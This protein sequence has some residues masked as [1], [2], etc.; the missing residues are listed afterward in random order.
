ML[1]IWLKEH[2]RY[3]LFE[4]TLTRMTVYSAVPIGA[5]VAA[6]ARLYRIRR[7]RLGEAW[8]GGARHGEVRRSRAGA[9][10]HLVVTISPAVQSAPAAASEADVAAHS[11]PTYCA[12]ISFSCG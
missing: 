9:N 8:L 12:S 1:P 7:S 3:D 4:N 5:M 10:C 11:A 2:S 6:G